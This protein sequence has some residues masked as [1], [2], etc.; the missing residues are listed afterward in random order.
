MAFADFPRLFEAQYSTYTEDLPFWL[1]LASD[2]DGPVLELGCGPG[3]VLFA[4]AR[5]GKTADG[6]DND[7]AMLDR[8]RR[9]LTPDLAGRVRLHLADLRRFDLNRTFALALLPCN[10]FAQLT[11][12]DAISSLAAIRRHLLSGATLAIDL[13]HPAES[14]LPPEAKNEPILAY[15]EPETGNPIQV[16]ASQQFD[17]DSR[18]VDVIWHYDELLSDG[19]VLRTDIPTGYYLRAPERMR[20]LLEIGGFPKAEFYGD[21]DRTPFAPDS[22]RLIV[23]ARAG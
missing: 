23:V 10:T 3:R 12:T 20:R 16:Y 19:R 15:L 13:P 9:H 2:L 7:P 17:A 18:R 11:D 22:S 8:A 1:S 14:L 6:L 5:A 21:Y 4:L